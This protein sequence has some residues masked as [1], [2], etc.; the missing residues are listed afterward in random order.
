MAAIRDGAKAVSTKHF[1]QSFK[2]VFPSIKKDDMESV[3]K[4][5]NSPIGAMYR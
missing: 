5:K 4:F 2:A 3:K 1:E